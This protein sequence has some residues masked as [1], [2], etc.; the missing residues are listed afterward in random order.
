MTKRV[1]D[2]YLELCA[3]EFEKAPAHKLRAENV[4]LEF[5]RINC[6]GYDTDFTAWPGTQKNVHYWV[7]TENRHAI[8]MNENPS[9]GISFPV[10]KLNQK[11][12]RELLAQHGQLPLIPKKPKRLKE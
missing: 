7:V 12:Y 5:C 1:S 10:I 4:V 6:C 9:I 3:G 8:G 11:R 2:C